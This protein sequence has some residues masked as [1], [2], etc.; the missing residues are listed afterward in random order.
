[1]RVTDEW[2]G[3]IT[4]EPVVGMVQTD[5]FFAVVLSVFCVYDC[6]RL[7]LNN[8]AFSFIYEGDDASIQSC[9]SKI[10]YLPYVTC[11]YS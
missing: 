8:F 7:L 9:Y 6:T 10:P 3:V 2:E 11:P 1:M 4:H 5:L